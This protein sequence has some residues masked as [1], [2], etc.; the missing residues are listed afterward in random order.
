MTKKPMKIDGKK[1]AEQI[2]NDLIFK[3]QDLRSKN[4]VPKIA[5]ITL[6]PEDSWETYVRQKIKVAGELGIK[7]VLINLK[8]SDEEELIRTVRKIDSDPH[9]HGIIIQ[10]PIPSNLNR[11]RVVNSISPEK[12]VDGF[13]P[14]SKFEIPVWLAVRRLLEESLNLKLKTENKKL[15]E[16]K[17]VV[18]GKGETA[19]SPIIRGLKKM[20]IEPK[21]IDT[22]TVNPDE[23]LKSADIIISCVGK[24]NVIHPE[25]IKK[26][27]I[28]IGVGTHGEDLKLRG[29]YSV[30]DI[31]SIAGAYTP[32]PGGVGPVNLSYL[33]SNLVHAASL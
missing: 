19:G 31:E 30:K 12:D 15:N 5:I 2:R 13:R 14:D 24:Q 18:I 20:G 21:V 16:L 10:R 17:F 6:G 26:G 7:A 23:I 3:I 11:E 25:Q 22:R 1:I 29:D 4:I 27:A 32:T 8:D 28:L 9:Y 33:F